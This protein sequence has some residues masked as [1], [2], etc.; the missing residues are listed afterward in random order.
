MIFPALALVT[1]VSS[2]PARSTAGRID[3]Y[4]ELI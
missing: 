4:N 1:A 2:E 3:G